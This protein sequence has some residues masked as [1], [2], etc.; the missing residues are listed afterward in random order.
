MQALVIGFGVVLPESAAVGVAE[1]ITPSTDPPSRSRHR[2]CSTADWIGRS[3]YSG[4]TPERTRRADPPG[5][6]LSSTRIPGGTGPSCSV[7][8]FE[9]AAQTA[10]QVFG[11]RNRGPGSVNQHRHGSALVGAGQPSPA[12]FGGRATSPWVRI[13]AGLRRSLPRCPFTIGAQLGTNP[14]GE[15]WVLPEVT[16]TGSGVGRHL[17]SS[18]EPTPLGSGRAAAAPFVEPGARSH[19]QKP[20]GNRDHWGTPWLVLWAAI[21]DTTLIVSPP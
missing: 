16:N 3:G 17:P 6:G 13:D 12:P 18:A 1:S 10:G 7:D 4:V 5:V 15:P 21:C 20:T 9:I 2:R 11:R 8:L 19:P 14:C